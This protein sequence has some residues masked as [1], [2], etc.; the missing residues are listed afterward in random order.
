MSSSP[1]PGAAAL[2]EAVRTRGRIEGTLVKVDD[3]LNH[4]VDPTLMD[5]IGA[6]IAGRW[7]AD[8]IDD[9]VTA[10]ASGIPPAL[11]AARHLGV[12]MIYAKKYPRT[13]SDRP[14]FVREVASPT[15]GTEYR[16]EVARRVLQPRR[17][18]LVVDDFLSGGRTAEALGEIVEEAGSI[19]AGFAFVIEKSFVAGRSRLE[20]RGWSVDSLLLVESL[21]GVLRVTPT[22]GRTR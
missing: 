13:T 1:T 11:A 15:K 9:V 10:E 14:A 8:A 18:V 17:R 2:A 7:R 21:D 12:E 4:R 6:D 20:E 22:A 19:V 16:V 3:F 5:L